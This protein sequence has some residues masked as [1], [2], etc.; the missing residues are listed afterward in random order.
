VEWIVDPLKWC[1]LKCEPLTHCR[2]QSL[3]SLYRRRDLTS[4]DP[5]DRRLIGAC[6]QGQDAL[7]DAMA[8]PGLSDDFAGMHFQYYA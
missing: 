8:L 2:K 4:L 1:A 7:A 5:A 6:P 3:D